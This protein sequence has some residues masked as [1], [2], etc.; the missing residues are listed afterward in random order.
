MH[1]S[2]GS[3]LRRCKVFALAVFFVITW[4]GAANAR[5]DF[6]RRACAGRHSYVT[7]TDDRWLSG[8]A[9]LTGS[10]AVMQIRSLRFD[11][12]PERLFALPQS[13]TAYAAPARTAS[14]AVVDAWFG[15]KQY[16]RFSAK[17]KIFLEARFVGHWK[18]SPIVVSPT[19][20]LGTIPAL[21]FRDAFETAH[22]GSLYVIGI[23]LTDGNELHV[24]DLGARPCESMD[25]ERQHAALNVSATTTIDLLLP[26][27]T[28]DTAENLSASDVP[29]DLVGVRTVFE[30]PYVGEVSSQAIADRTPVHVLGRSAMGFS[31][32]DASGLRILEGA[33]FREASRQEPLRAKQ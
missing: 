7:L 2:A 14:G 20:A 16:R 24:F 6:D 28:V 3:A 30:M 19:V 8:V 31:L 33:F 21:E 32:Y 13:Q 18:V 10:N 27:F 12:Y 17:T 4:S 11:P 23:P 25:I 22:V 29:R 15:S 26:A 9:R 5:R 1:F